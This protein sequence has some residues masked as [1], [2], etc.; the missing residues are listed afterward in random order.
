MTTEAFDP[1]FVFGGLGKVL[2][3]NA[4]ADLEEKDPELASELRISVSR[5]GTPDRLVT[6]LTRRGAPEK[7][8]SWLSQAANHLART[9]PK[10]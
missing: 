2:D 6:Y 1:D 9:I 7:L 8:I 3:A 4:W 5:N 10:G